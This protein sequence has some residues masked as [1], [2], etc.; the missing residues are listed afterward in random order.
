M[1]FWY[2]LRSINPNL[3][4]PQS[5]VSLNICLNS[6][7]VYCTKFSNA[8]WTKSYLSLSGGQSI[9]YGKLCGKCCSFLLN[10]SP[11]SFNGQTFTCKWQKSSS[12]SIIRPGNWPGANLFSPV[13]SSKRCARQTILAAKLAL[14]HFPP[15]RLENPQKKNGWK[16]GK[17]A[18]PP[19]GNERPIPALLQLIPRSPSRFSLIPSHR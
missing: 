14:A 4:L 3:F 10:Y 12:K 8:I 19:G 7:A 5:L 6:R 11:V 9:F 2:S 13:L 15:P 1:K 17:Y 16:C 18:A